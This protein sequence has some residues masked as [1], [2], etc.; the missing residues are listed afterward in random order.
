MYSNWYLRGIAL[1]ISVLKLLKLL[2]KYEK[3]KQLSGMERESV[4][5]DTVT[6]YS[7]FE[8]ITEGKAL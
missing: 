2:I 5:L 8:D 3:Y 4:V 6:L 7:D 1:F